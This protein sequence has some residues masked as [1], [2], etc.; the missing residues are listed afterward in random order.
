MNKLSGEPVNASVPFPNTCD[1]NKNAG[2]EY[3][4]PIEYDG[5]NPAT[6]T[7][8]RHV[9]GKKCGSD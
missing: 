2:R 3:M 4:R 5:I 6:L 7:G 1:E 9:G 8:K